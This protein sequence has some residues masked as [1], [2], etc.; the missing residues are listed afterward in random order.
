LPL[1]CPTHI[2]LTQQP[3]PPIPT[4]ILHIG[5][6]LDSVFDFSEEKR[7][8]KEQG[9]EAYK[10]YVRSH[11][12][13]PLEPAKA[14]PFVAKMLSFNDSQNTLVQV[15]LIANCT[16]ETILRAKHSMHCHKLIDPLRP[17]HCS[18]LTAQ[19][20]GNALN[21]VLSR[22][23]VDLF[24]SPNPNDVETLLSL[25]Y[26]AG[27]VEAGRARDEQFENYKAA[28]I[29]FD[30]DRVIGVACG[31]DGTK[32]QFIDNDN[33]TTVQGL[34]AAWQREH[35][36][37]KT[38]AHKGPL[39]PFFEKLF[40]LR[41]LVNACPDKYNL[42]IPIVTARTGQSLGR[43][44]TT[45]KAWGIEP[46]GI[47]STGWDR[48]GEVLKDIHATAHFDD[49]LKHIQEAYEKSPQTTPF[50]VPWVDTHLDQIKKRCH[51]PNAPM[52]QLRPAPAYAP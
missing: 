35:E 25:G 28:V 52:H 9:N 27:H 5:V 6:S 46:D 20:G 43:V 7:L 19:F 51:C 15:T 49:S 11:L 37:R 47:L 8:L 45:L 39:S 1:Y 12:F 22:N 38:P 21:K 14:F 31:Q 24:L 34:E 48:K 23:S 33:Y 30:F 16:P 13:E 44:E 32:D 2:R 36:C 4:P 29:A 26:C 10:K 41:D 42:S 3:P 17:E 40:A 50:H 18:G